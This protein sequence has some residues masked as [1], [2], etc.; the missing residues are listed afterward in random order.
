MFKITKLI[1]CPQKGEWIE[2]GV[3]S[4]CLS[5]R[6]KKKTSYRANMK[7]VLPGERST[8]L[9]WAGNPLNRVRCETSSRRLFKQTMPD[10]TQP[11]GHLTLYRLPLLPELSLLTARPR[12][13]FVVSSS[14]SFFT[15]AFS[16]SCRR[17]DRTVFW[18]SSAATLLG[19]LVFS[20]LS[21]FC[22]SLPL[23]RFGLAIPLCFL[24][25]TLRTTSGLWHLR[26]L[27]Y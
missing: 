22:D 10:R 17:C 13:T 15:A 11:E 2:H 4:P 19:F 12:S 18:R 27:I 1:K 7:A 25:S 14:W 5:I 16:S 6:Q 8:A 20:A 26:G 9:R 21:T 3:K 23:R 24:F